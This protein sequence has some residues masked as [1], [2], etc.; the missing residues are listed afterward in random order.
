MNT[1]VFLA[2]DIGIL[3]AGLKLTPDTHVSSCYKVVVVR[4]DVLRVSEVQR[5]MKGL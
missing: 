4:S 2:S 1:M 5:A 3:A